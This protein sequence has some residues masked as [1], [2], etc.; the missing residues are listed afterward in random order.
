MIFS[1]V[2]DWGPLEQAARPVAAMTA[3]HIVAMRD[4]RMSLSLAILEKGPSQTHISEVCTE[5]ATND[6][7]IPSKSQG[8]GDS[9]L[10]QKWDALAKIAEKNGQ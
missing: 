1:L 2:A 8:E 6:E 7:A 4:L 3:M 10:T 9:W 5:T